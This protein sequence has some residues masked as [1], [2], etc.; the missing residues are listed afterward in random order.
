MVMG[1]SVIA[2]ALIAIQRAGSAQRGD[3]SPGPASPVSEPDEQP[4]VVVEAEIPDE[5]G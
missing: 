2:F 1:I 3:P 4:P 5:D